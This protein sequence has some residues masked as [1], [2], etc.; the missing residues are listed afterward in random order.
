MKKYLVYSLVAL[1]AFIPFVGRAHVD[2]GLEGHSEV[3][4]HNVAFGTETEVEGSG[5]LFGKRDDDR[6]G[7][8]GNHE[9]DDSDR[10]DKRE[11]VRMGFWGGS[12]DDHRNIL[13]MSV[14]MRFK[15]A[16][17][18]LNG[19]FDR[20][21]SRIEKIKTEGKDTTAAEGYLSSAK[22]SY[23][24]ATAYIEAATALWDGTSTDTTVDTRIEIRTDLQNAKDKIKETVES[25]KLCIQALKD[26]YVHTD[27]DVKVEENTE[28]TH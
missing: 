7:L 25:L 6:G 19:F 16:T 13:G 22:T 26:L 14:V 10:G 20:I 23:A 28:E 1:F 9:N 3:D 21:D 15:M 18:H 4:K 2:V 12:K 11:D 8:F 24:A 17:I 5:G 27:T